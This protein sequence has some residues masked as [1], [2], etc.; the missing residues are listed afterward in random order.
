MTYLFSST[1]HNLD[2][3]LFDM[4]LND[5]GLVFVF[6]SESLIVDD[7]RFLLLKSLCGWT[8]RHVFLG[9]HSKMKI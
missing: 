5:F 6:E 4:I 2:R 1:I 3:D 8:F 9:W 7:L